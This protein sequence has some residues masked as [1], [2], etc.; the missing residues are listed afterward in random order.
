MTLQYRTWQYGSLG[1]LKK[2]FICWNIQLGQIVRLVWVE[3]KAKTTKLIDKYFKDTFYQDGFLFVYWWYCLITFWWS[4]D[5]VSVSFKE[6]VGK[7]PKVYHIVELYIVS[8]LA[9]LL[10]KLLIEILRENSKS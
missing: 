10:G 6:N 4:Y 5:D 8:C 1:L 2:P 3:F 7:K 9:F